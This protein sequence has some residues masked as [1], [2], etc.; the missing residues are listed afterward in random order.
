MKEIPLTQGKTALVDDADY[1]WLNRYKWCTASVA[2][3]ADWAR[4]V[5]A[6]EV[7]AVNA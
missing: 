1:E 5:D 4:E 2:E 3:I 6:P 7:E